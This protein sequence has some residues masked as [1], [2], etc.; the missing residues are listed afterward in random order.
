MAGKRKA[1]SASFKAK[2]AL[3]ALKG[4]KTGSQLASEYGVHPTLTTTWK[5]QLLD[6]VE[7]AFGSPAKADA[8]DAEAL[9]SELYEQI[10]RLKRELDWVKKKLPSSAEAKRELVEEGHASLS[11]CRQCELP[12]LGRS[13]Y[14]YEPVPESAENLRLMRRIDEQYTNCP[15]YG[16][17]LGYRTPAQVYR[18]E[19]QRTAG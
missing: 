9:Q 15:V 14:Y 13:S 16:S 6:G 12:G 5:K 10:G 8:K 4:D 18:E 11:V 19:R 7:A 17:S 3:A 1:Y 2:V